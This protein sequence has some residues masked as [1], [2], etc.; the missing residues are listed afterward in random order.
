MRLAL[1]VIIILC[2]IAT[3]GLKWSETD[4]QKPKD[5]R[6]ELQKR[7]IQRW[8]IYKA[9]QQYIPN[10]RWLFLLFVAL[11]TYYLIRNHLK[12]F[13]LATIAELKHPADATLMIAIIGAPI[14]YVIWWFRDANTRQQIENQ[15]KDV[16]L[17][18]FQRIAE[19]A[20]GMHLPENKITTSEK[21]IKSKA[22]DVKQELIENKTSSSN[23][24][25]TSTETSAIPS[26]TVI[27]T[28]SRR[29]G[30]ASLQ[31]AAIYQLQAFLQGEYGRYFQRPA[32]QLLKSIWLAL[33]SQD[34]A[35]LQEIM[36]EERDFAKTEELETFKGTLRQWKS[37]L[38]A[39]MNSPIGEA[40]TVAIGAKQGWLL[41]THQAD[42]PNAILS[43]YNSRLAA[44]K[45]PLELDGLNLT[46]IKL[47]GADL[48]GVQLH[49][50]DLR[51]AE[52]QGANL[53]NAKLQG[54]DFS[55]AQLEGVELMDAKLQ[56]ANLR[57]TKLQGAI[58]NSAQLQG[59]NLNLAQLQGAS[60]NLAQLRGAN[61]VQAQLQGALLSGA[62]M[63]N[64]YLGKANLK[65]SFLIE[66]HMQNAN[67]ESTQLQNANLSGAQM[68]NAI[69]NSSQM[70]N[71][72]L[73][74]TNLQ[75]AFLRE[76][77]LQGSL[78]VMVQLEGADL[79]NLII[80]NN[81]KFIDCRVNEKT[82]VLV[83]PLGKRVNIEDTYT[84]RSKLRQQ[85]LILPDVLY[86]QLYAE[87]TEYQFINKL[88]EL[89]TRYDI[90][91]FSSFT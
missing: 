47:Q 35:D 30:A 76:T 68:E 39:T 72:Y 78:L 51:G 4:N 75:G 67:L 23:E 11:V 24:T 90:G 83:I 50:S 19:W 85:G 80:D 42:L 7:R 40:I 43:G 16:N 64:A 6:R 59:A 17:K 74:E 77:Q 86:E 38:Q 1:I 79:S 53:N 73:N 20:A 52:L 10:L 31:I 63:Q 62:Y 32:F 45:Q 25:L 5:W 55:D 48:R 27:H 88:G 61:L 81:T 70:Q 13:N 60:L 34:L 69:L 58:L 15:R 49:G 71:M 65:N 44:L 56:G 28:P 46:G 91:L 9:W 18:D 22:K 21:A 54:V 87:P 29:E 66:T 41:R 89:E 37:N 84:L 82:L 3:F 14:A 36:Q 2:A 57:A 8:F 33:V 26:G 12:D